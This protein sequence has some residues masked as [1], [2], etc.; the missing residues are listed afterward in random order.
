MI[1]KRISIILAVLAVF[2]FSSFLP[3]TLSAQSLEELKRQVNELEIQ[4]NSIEKNIDAKQ[5]ESKTLKNRLD[6]LRQNIQKR[7][8]EIKKTVLL[9]QKLNLEVQ[10]KQSSLQTTGLKI[11]L[12]EKLLINYIREL[13]ELDKKDAISI[14]LTSP[15]ISDFFDQVK[16]VEGV[17]EKTSTILSSLKDLKITLAKEKED[18]EDNRVDAIN[19][20]SLSEI[21]KKNLDLEKKQKDNLLKVTK[22]EEAQ[23]QKTL[24]DKKQVLANLKSQLFYLEATGVSVEDALKYADLA[25]RKAGI[26]TA[27]LLAVLEVETGRQ[28]KNGVLT[29]GTNLGSGNWKTDLYNCYVNLG[30]RS[31]AETQ[32][33]AYFQIT[34]ELHYDPDKMPV[35]RKPKYGCGGAMGPAQFLPAT[36]LL[37]KDRVASAIG[38]NPPDPWKVEASFM[39]AALYLSDRGATKQTET[40][41]RGAAKAYISGSSTCSTYTCNIYSSN[42]VSLTRIIDNTI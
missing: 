40:A 3:K 2:V 39:A 1:R 9:I 5:S 36:W 24:K 35:S 32:K 19:L 11:D 15:R 31:A 10:N 21:E 18:L 33:K 34:D 37:Y 12:S 28:F 6:V 41:E 25:A 30:K 13:S 7:E 27:F 29:V 20:K 8:I 17:Q 23:Y 38:Q 16:A 22:G 42:I 14:V 4:V 26:R